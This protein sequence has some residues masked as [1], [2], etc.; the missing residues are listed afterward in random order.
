VNLTLLSQRLIKGLEISASVYNLF[1]THFA[2]P[3]SQD[4]LQDTITQDGRGFRIKLTYR[5]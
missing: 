4:L 2:F 1:D 3:V 5:F